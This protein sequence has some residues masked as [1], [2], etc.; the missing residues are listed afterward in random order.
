MSGET[1]TTIIISHP[2]DIGTT[3]PKPLSSR[4]ILIIGIVSGTIAILLLLGFIYIW[5][6]RKRKTENDRNMNIDQSSKYLL[7]SPELHFG[8]D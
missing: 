6:R 7:H 3:A 2:G 5:W 1:T 8:V 4:Q